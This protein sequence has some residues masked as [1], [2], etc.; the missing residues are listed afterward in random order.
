M[1]INS[2]SAGSD[3]TQILKMMQST[4][5]EMAEKLLKMDA[6]LSTEAQDMQT[7]ETIID[8]YI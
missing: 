8:L 1:E 5:A 7:K 2:S 4:S 3:I 6:Q